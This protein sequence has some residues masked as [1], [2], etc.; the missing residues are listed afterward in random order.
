MRASAAAACL[1]V[2][3]AAVPLALADAGEPDY[4][5]PP[6]TTSQA[7][8]D[9]DPQGDYVEV[10]G[11]VPGDYADDPAAGTAV[12]PE[13]STPEM[14]VAPMAPAPADG[15]SPSAAEPAGPP[16]EVDEMVWAIC[17][18]VSAACGMADAC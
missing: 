13:A 9:Y 6:A 3:A 18:L 4:V 17:G 14:A 2:L 10:A 15:P 7:D 5:E 12:N 16:M 1:V 11:E 8:Q